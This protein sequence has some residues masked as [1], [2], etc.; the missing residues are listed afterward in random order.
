MSFPLILFYFSGILLLRWRDWGWHH[1]LDDSF[2]FFEFSVIA[3]TIPDHAFSIGKWSLIIGTDLQLLLI[4]HRV[5]PTEKLLLPLKNKVNSWK[6]TLKYMKIFF[7]KP[8][9]FG[10]ITWYLVR[11]SSILRNYSFNKSAENL[12]S[13]NNFI[14]NLAWT[15][16]EL[17]NFVWNNPSSA[18][19]GSFCQARSTLAS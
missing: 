7:S 10:S 12:F 19:K 5:T 18:Q 16:K 17:P 1:L 8:K 15:L 9:F 14:L 2:R 4:I 3:T 13:M 11:P 6:L